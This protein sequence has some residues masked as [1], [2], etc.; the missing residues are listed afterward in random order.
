MD[1][2]RER[3]EEPGVGTR[4]LIDSTAPWLKRAKNSMISAWL[5]FGSIILSEKEIQVGISNDD[6]ERGGD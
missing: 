6:R 4:R 3:T 5:A 2:S 1:Y